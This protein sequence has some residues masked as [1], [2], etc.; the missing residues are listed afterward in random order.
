MMLF[1]CFSFGLDGKTTPKLSQL[2]R[3]LTTGIDNLRRRCA[4]VAGEHGM[5]ASTDALHAFKP[6][7]R[8]IYSTHINT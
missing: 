4:R 3:H 1:V 7:Q 2:K 5:A 6:W 8:S